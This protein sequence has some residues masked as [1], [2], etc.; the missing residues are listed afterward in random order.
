MIGSPVAAAPELAPHFASPAKA[1]DAKPAEASAA[2][3]NPVNALINLMSFLPLLRRF[4][5]RSP[6]AVV[7]D[8]VQTS[9]DTNYIDHVRFI[10]VFCQQR[11][12]RQAK[13]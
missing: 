12:T 10:A 4:F 11:S 13:Q 3:A 1:V 9:L 7:R 6:I 5:G 8:V 2:T